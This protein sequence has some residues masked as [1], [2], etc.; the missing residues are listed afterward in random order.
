MDKFNHYILRIRRNYTHRD[1]LDV[2]ADVILVEQLAV[3]AVYRAMMI[4]SVNVVVS[5]LFSPRGFF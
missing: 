1:C 5:K 3:L 2:N 4:K